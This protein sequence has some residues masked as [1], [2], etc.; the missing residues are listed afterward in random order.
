M[1]SILIF[2][3][4]LYTLEYRRYERTMKH[5]LN[6]HQHKVDENITDSWKEL[7]EDQRYYAYMIEIDGITPQI[8]T[9]IFQTDLNNL[10]IEPAT[11]PLEETIPQ[12][13]P[14]VH[15]VYGFG[16]RI[17]FSKQ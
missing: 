9:A 16:T 8:Q 3:S 10:H 13:D 1:S 2:V 17:P 4:K 11:I 12:T 5:A 15:T 7:S 14:R 6:I